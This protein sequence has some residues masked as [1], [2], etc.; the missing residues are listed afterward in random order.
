MIL[1][2]KVKAH[3]TSRNTVSIILT[4]HGI[5]ADLFFLTDPNPPQITSVIGI[6]E[7]TIKL[8]WSAGQCNMGYP[9]EI[10]ISVFKRNGELFKQNILN[11]TSYNES[12][13]IG[14]TLFEKG[15][16]FNTSYT[17]WIIDLLYNGTTEPVWSRPS[18]DYFATISGM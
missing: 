16:D 1:L 18:P 12:T 15:Q 4:S 10:S 14:V 9:R 6:S 7:S 13:G 2:S 11:I 3:S 17:Q 5:D 8:T